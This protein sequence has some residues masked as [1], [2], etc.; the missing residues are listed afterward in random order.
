MDAGIY[1]FK[2]KI[3]GKCYVG[4]AKSLKKRINHHYS[5]IKTQRY[6][7]PI[8]KAINKYGIENFDLIILK[9]YPQDINKK[10]LCNQMDKDEKYYIEKYDSYLN[11]YNCTL[12]G[13]G[14]V[15]GY[16]MTDEQKDK[17]RRNSK[18][19]IINRKMVYMYNVKEK[20]Y[21]TAISVSA[22]SIITGLSRSNIGRVANKTYTKNNIKYFLCSFSKEDLQNQI[23]SLS[24]DDI[25]KIIESDN[26][27]QFKKG[28][29]CK[30]GGR[31][32]GTKLSDNHKLNISSSL[33]KYKYIEIYDKNNSLI[34]TFKYKED[35][36][37]FLSCSKG[38]VRDAINGRVKTCK[39]YS[40]KQIL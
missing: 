6:N 23:E 3:N 19:S 25:K 24:D 33:K 13:D 7:L 31:K 22:A 5:N 9:E 28:H 38:S 1:M 26:N 4:Q 21:I 12:G 39:G 16:K 17:I 27:G 2:N 32:P 14:G 11:G 30:N 20:Y 35:V 18:I 34:K 36:A 37:E 8:Y 15:L 40:L 10:I 29:I